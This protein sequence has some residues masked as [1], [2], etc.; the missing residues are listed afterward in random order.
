MKMP[1]MDPKLFKKELKEIQKL[2]LI[3]TVSPNDIET[4]TEIE[5]IED[6][7]KKNKKLVRDEQIF[8]LAAR[9]LKG[10]SHTIMDQI[11][12]KRESGYY[13]IGEEKYEDAEVEIIT[14]NGSKR[15]VNIEHLEIKQSTTVEFLKDFPTLNNFY[16][17]SLPY[18]KEIKKEMEKIKWFLQLKDSDF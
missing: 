11:K 18:F 1:D 9:N 17:K 14:K 4:K 8:S 13:K 3:R 12:N 5:L 7:K 16:K 6:P 15:K 10:I 2:H